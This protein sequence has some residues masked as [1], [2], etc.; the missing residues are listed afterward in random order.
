[1]VRKIRRDL[2][3]SAAT[4]SLISV[5]S[6]HS[7]PS[8]FN[9]AGRCRATIGIPSS[10]LARTALREII[11]ANGWVASITQSV[12][13]SESHVFRPATPPKPPTRMGTDA[14]SGCRVR[15][16]SD[17]ITS[18]SAR[19]AS[20]PARA[21]ASA[22]PPRMRMRMCA[23]SPNSAPESREA[24]ALARHRRHRRGRPR[25][26]VGGGARGGRERG[27][28]RGRRAPPRAGRTA[29]GRDR[30]LVSSD[31]RHLSPHRGPAPPAGLRSRDRRSLSLRRRGRAWQSSSRRRR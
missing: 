7:S 15:P 9:H 1:M 2:S 28:C 6:I 27:S 31:R 19:L 23:L 14:A 22:V 8:V 18:V 20:R 17:S 25:R 3:P 12:R 26:A 21:A 16:A 4:A 30:A 13:F 24:H 11:A 29:D 5:T 10:P